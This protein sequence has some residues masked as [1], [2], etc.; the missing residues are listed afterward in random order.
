MYKIVIGIFGVLLACAEPSN[1]GL[2]TSSA[3]AII[4]GDYSIIIARVKD[5]HKEV[6]DKPDST[7]TLTIEPLA[8]IA[9]L[10]DPSKYATIKVAL[11]AATESSVDAAPDRGSL[12]LAVI[13]PYEVRGERRICITAS[14]CTFM[15]GGSACV[16]V[17]GMNDKRILQTL[18][19]V[20]EER[21]KIAEDRA[22]E[23]KRE[24]DKG[25]IGVH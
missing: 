15:P 16:T 17:T 23:V 2:E 22:K 19:W 18:D 5:V 25:P 10:F 21:V 3:D 9:G 1:G 13:H 12:I 11:W 24:P 20:R 6:G 8:T 7:H 14:M 4:G